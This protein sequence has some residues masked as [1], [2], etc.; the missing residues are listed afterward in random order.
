[1]KRTLCMV[2]KF[3]LIFFF[4]QCQTQMF[5]FQKKK[6]ERIHLKWRLA[7]TGPPRW[8]WWWWAEAGDEVQGPIWLCQFLYDIIILRVINFGM[9]RSPTA[10]T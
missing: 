3:I 2:Y 8:W 9:L 10:T 7:V 6:G 1:M 4:L 5:H